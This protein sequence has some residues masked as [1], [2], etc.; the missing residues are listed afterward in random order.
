MRETEDSY[1]R[2]AGPE[3]SRKGAKKLPTV[4]KEQVYDKIALM[5]PV[6][7]YAVT[8]AM[9]EEYKVKGKVLYQ[10]PI[11]GCFNRL[12]QAGRIV[13]LGK[14]TK[15]ATGK[16]G[17][18]WRRSTRK[19]KQFILDYIGPKNP[20]W[21]GGDTTLEEL[22]KVPEIRNAIKKHA[23]EK[24]W[25]LYR[26]WNKG[27]QFKTLMKDNGIEWFMQNYGTNGKRLDDE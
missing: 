13:P 14:T 19:E 16:Q 4:T 21:A 5:E 25:F 11:S 15:N 8:M 17:G 24:G 2:R 6:T 1:A 12:C 22:S 26:K 23:T 7:Q 9:V 3:T 10:D 18:L 27:Y 20:P